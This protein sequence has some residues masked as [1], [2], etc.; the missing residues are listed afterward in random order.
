MPTMSRPKAVAV[1]TETEIPDWDDG[2]PLDD[3]PVLGADQIIQSVGD[4]GLDDDRHRRIAERA[5]RR[6]ERRGFS[7]GHELDDWLAAEIEDDE[8]QDEQQR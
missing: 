3:Y 7:P 8:Q 6:A 1:P 4:A 5:Y 2:G